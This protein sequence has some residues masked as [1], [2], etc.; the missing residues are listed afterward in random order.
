M[1]VTD[2]SGLGA[3]HTVITTALPVAAG[4][5]ALVSDY[6][7]AGAAASPGDSRCKYSWRG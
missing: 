7:S 3:A 2:V 1:R 4:Q 5:P 6:A